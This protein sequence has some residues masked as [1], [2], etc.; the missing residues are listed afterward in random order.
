[1]KTERHIVLFNPAFLFSFNLSAE[2]LRGKPVNRV[3]PELPL[4]DLI[5]Q[6]RPARAVHTLEIKLA[7]GR[8]FEATG[9]GVREEDELTAVVTVLRDVTKERQ[10][11]EIK[12]DFISTVSHELR[13]PLTPVVGFTKLIRKAFNKSILPALPQEQGKAQR[14]AERIN[15]N[16]KFMLK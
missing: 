11:D 8:V 2:G 6:T 9:A 3:L 4:Q 16:L 13:T 12:S 1:M 14:A 5:L 7:D 15:Q 10:L